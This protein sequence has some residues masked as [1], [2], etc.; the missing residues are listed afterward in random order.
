MMRLAP[1]L[2]IAAANVF[3]GLG[4]QPQD[5]AKGGFIDR[6]RCS[7]GGEAGNATWNVPLLHYWGYWSQ[8]DHRR[9]CSIWPVP[10][11]ESASALAAFGA[12]MGVLHEEPLPG[13]IFVQFAPR[14]RRFVHAGIVTAVEGSGRITRQHTYV[15]VR[16]IE[17][18]TN[19]RGERGGGRTMSLRRRLSASQGDRFLRW[20]ELEPSYGQ[21]PRELEVSDASGR[22]DPPLWRI[23]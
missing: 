14:G 8:Y 12:R 17:G 20:A 7:A 2:F 13:D 15:V 16:T 18:D 19:E 5:H 3:S 21:L 4:D 9:E 22:D 6:L 1:L 10:V 23:G 11:R